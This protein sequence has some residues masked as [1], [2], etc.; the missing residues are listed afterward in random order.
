MNGPKVCQEMLW[1]IT[2]AVRTTCPPLKKTKLHFKS[3]VHLF[4]I[5]LINW[6]LLARKS[7]LKCHNYRMF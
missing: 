1:I 3:E 4:V 5:F 7:A 2:E 6:L